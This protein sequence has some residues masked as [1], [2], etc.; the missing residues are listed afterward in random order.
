MKTNFWGVALIGL[1]TLSAYTFRDENY[2][3]NTKLSILEWTGKKLTGEHSG[4]I[5]L[6]DGTMEVKKGEIKSGTFVIDMSTIQ[7]KDLS[8]EWKAKMEGHLKSPDF[9]D[10]EKFPKAT[11]V[12]TSVTPVN[13]SAAGFT[14][15][16]NGNLTM[17]GITNPISFDATIRSNNNTLA[18][19]G[20]A[21]IDRSKFNVQYGSKTFFNDIGDKIVYD[22]FTLKFNVVA[23]MDQYK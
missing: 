2:T 12:I 22:E 7:D 11:F 4:T 21:V 3:V 15:H 6:S 19:L 18:C 1:I 16:V 23:Q 5:Q 20:T 13:G 9:F 8:G 14:H 10:V 17:K